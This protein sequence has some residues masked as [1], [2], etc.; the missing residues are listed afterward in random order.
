MKAHRNIRP[1]RLA[2][3]LLQWFCE[4]AQI[5]DLQ[6]DIEELFYSD[7]KIMSAR[8][9]KLKYWKRVLS[10]LFSY[11]IKK[12][13][14]RSAFHPY[15]GSSINYSMIRSYFKIAYRAMLRSKGYS[16]INITGLSIGLACCMLIFLY[17]KDEISYDRFHKN[18]KNIYQLTCDR[19]EVNGYSKKFA[20]AAMVQGPAFAKEIPEIRSFVRTKNQPVTIRLGTDVFHEDVL[21]ADDNFFSVF[22]FPLIAG[23]SERALSNMHSLVIT[24][25]M[26]R[27]YFGTEN[28]VGRTLEIQ[29]D[30]EFEMFT[31]S[32]ISKK[33]PENSTIKFRMILPF[34]YLEEIHPDNGW[35]WVSFQTYFLLNPD[36]DPIAVKS[37]MAKVYET[38]A[39]PEIDEMRSMGYGDK[40]IW[41]LLPFS[42]M[43]LNSEY[44]GVANASDPIYS[45]VLTG[46][47][48]FIL[49]IACINFINIAVA[50][51]LRRSKEIGIRKVIGSQ[52]FQLV[53]QF[54]SE[55]FLLCFLAFLLAVLMTQLSLP[56]F[57]NLANKQL[58]L[59]YLLDSNLVVGFSALLFVTSFVS[60]FYPVLV[61]SGLSPVKS[62]H[63][64]KKSISGNYLAKSL[65]VVQ[66][67]LAIMLI[68][69]ALVIH[70]QFNFLVEK[71]LGYQDENLV[72]VTVEKA[73]R[74]RAIS[75]ILKSEFS[76][77]PGVEIVATKN[78][79]KFQRP[80]KAGG[81]EFVAF[82]EHVDEDFIPTMKV[83]M[84]AGRNF[85]KQF[86]GD[87]TGAVLVN[88]A[89][90]KEVG[91]LDA[92]G[93]TVDYMDIPG[94]GDKKLIIVGIV[95]D[96]HFES[97]K[98][99]IKPQVFTYEPRLPQGKFLVRVEPENIF[100]TL[101]N[102][103]SSLR[104]IAPFDAFEYSFKE[105]VNREMY[106]SEARWKQIITL[107]A[108]LTIFISCIGLYGLSALT[109]ER[110][111]KEISIRKVLGASATFIVSLIAKD[112]LK[113]ILI[114]IFISVPIAW[115]CINQW[116]RNFSYKT[117]VTAGLFIF[118]SV[119][120]IAIALLSICT[121]AFKAALADSVNSLKND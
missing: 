21:W 114:S 50:Q 107:G 119:L 83:P 105:D 93:K 76:A 2:D 20:I 85:D 3:K 42:Q 101:T 88:E 97:L 43:H 90:V 36:C 19:V 15:S 7:S 65:V 84:A 82:Y 34:K 11:A 52:R 78:V 71:D 100:T 46:I 60:G 6:G 104:K 32:A 51:S 87:S 75:R 58:S 9:A 106:R 38:Q 18:E 91:W 94:W 47:A 31:V 73:V 80:V 102:L 98:E 103:E 66:F 53:V 27:K 118:A 63:A 23:N 57:N 30:G 86:P 62:L 68:I 1:P 111:T 120:A 22:T 95:S 92:I 108:F 16:F 64:G 89:F 14:Q 17:T 74:D 61:L 41:G 24:P 28:T 115:F 121:Q 45:Y 33:A 55:S 72:E 10:L 35:H 77:I 79:G 81:K 12:R 49:I 59:S 56:V 5:E 113:L 54:L 13:K 110:R 8:Q 44:E 25:E 4:N 26:S 112:F 48:V 29:V 109:T 40:F 69:G 117:D 37:K 96:Y 39:K 70:R 67:S 99:K 116:L